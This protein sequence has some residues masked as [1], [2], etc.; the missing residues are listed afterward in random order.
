MI[1]ESK[2]KIVLPRQ[3]VGLSRFSARQVGEREPID[4]VL[5]DAG[6]RFT[7]NEG[8][9]ARRKMNGDLDRIAPIRAGNAGVPE[10]CILI[11][12]LIFARLDVYRRDRLERMCTQLCTLQRKPFV[13]VR[14]RKICLNRDG[15][16]GPCHDRIQP[17]V[18]DG[19][20]IW[21]CARVPAAGGEAS[22]QGGDSNTGP[23][24]SAIHVRPPYL[25]VYPCYTFRSRA[26]HESWDPFRASKA[27]ALEWPSC[28]F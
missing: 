26:A 19:P 7:E 27:I 23:G 28:L 12:D 10:E 21:R 16:S 25:S 22:G 15:L 11:Y 20:S 24:A 18:E 3:V 8:P 5:N 1:C 4:R 13:S 14:V 17:L 6:I 9:V 2:V